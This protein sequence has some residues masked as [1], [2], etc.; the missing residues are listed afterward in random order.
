MKDRIIKLNIFADFNNK[1]E[2]NQQ[3][4]SYQKYADW[5]DNTE[6]IYQ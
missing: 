6:L 4:I 3:N 1:T 5:P 2:E